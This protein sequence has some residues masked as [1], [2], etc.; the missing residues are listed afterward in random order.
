[1][2]SKNFIRVLGAA[3]LFAFSLGSA[4]A[5]QIFFGPYAADATN[6]GTFDPRQND[7]AVFGSDVIGDFDH[8]WLFTLD[9]AGAAQAS[10]NFVPTG[11][12]TGFTA[13]LFAVGPACGFAVCPGIDLTGLT[14]LAT[15]ANDLGQVVLGFIGLD[16][17][18]YII[19]VFGNA[20]PGIGVNYSGQLA[21]ATVPE[22]TTLALLGLGLVGF[23]I[24]RRRRA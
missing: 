15:S 5:A 24:A 4:N 22:P 21:T 14:P 23:G 2:I 18:S 12:I 3:T 16:A 7:N 19:R 17:G 8:R 13:Q 1:M 9:P 11:G 10:A 6:M 20:T